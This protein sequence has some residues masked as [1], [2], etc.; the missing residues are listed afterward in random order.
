MQIPMK[1]ELESI[2]LDN[3]VPERSVI[4]LIYKTVE[5]CRITTRGSEQD[6]SPLVNF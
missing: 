5:R 1:C 2:V 3:L 4:N 6:L